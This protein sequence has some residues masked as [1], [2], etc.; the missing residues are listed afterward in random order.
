[1]AAELTRTPMRTPAAPTSA[2]PS[3]R[4]RLLGLGSVFGK[5]IRDSRR[6]MLI[7]GGISAVLVMVIAAA[8]VTEFSTPESRKEIA[9][10]IAAVPPIMQ[11]LAGSGFN[12]ETLGG[13]IQYK[14]GGF[15]PLVTGLWSILALSGTLAAEIRRGSLDF[16]AAGP[17][18]RRRIA[19]EK[20]LAHA[21]MVFVAM[22]LIMGALWVAGTA[23]AVLPGDEIPFSA[24]IGYALW[25]GLM[26]LAAGSVAFALAPFLGRGA[27]LGIAGSL[28]FLGFV[29]NGYRTAIPE[30]GQF[31]DL[32]WFGWTNDHI[33]LASKYDWASVGVT[34]A[35][36]VGMLA[37]GVEAFARR[38]LGSTIA[39][40][41]PRMPHAL[42]GLRGPFGRS[43]SERLPAA[44]SWGVGIGFFGLMM[45]SVGDTFT[46]QL[47]QAPGFRAALETLFPDVD[48]ASTGGFL[49]LVFIEF[50]LILAGLAGASLVSGWASDETSGRLE[51]L[52]AT[53]LQRTRWAVASGLGVL[54][55][56]VIVMAFTAVGIAIGGATAGGDVGTAVLGSGAVGLYGGALAGV[57]LAIGG[58][59]GAGVAGT[60][61]VAITILTW[62]LDF[63]VPSLDLPSWLQELALSSHMG[64]PMLGVWDV[65]GI[66]LCLVLAV[67]GV[68]LG[69]VTFARRDLGG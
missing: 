16:V 27:A 25:L 10:V 15:F 49:E 34:A 66:V 2:G 28:M 21:T 38:D 52:L 61:V 37:I 62:L 54:A 11:G 3:L 31:A 29:L 19:I 5:T 8:V 60:A 6:A 17:V 18:G 14:Y 9:R 30:L 58:I 7:V 55:G 22:A 65:P 47:A 46:D 56:V 24:A 44:I 35:F 40:P 67:G 26:A 64:Q 45:A 33:P 12:V 59:F 4:A 53:P 57:G 39:L 48:I 13:Y 68:V 41:M 42:V 32:T 43:L 50:G 51:L 36:A 20:V 23:F 1:M 69:A 63:L